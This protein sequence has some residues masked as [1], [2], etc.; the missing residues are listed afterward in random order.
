MTNIRIWFDITNT[1]HVNFFKPIIREFE[2]DYLLVFSIKD[3]AETKLLFE[4]EIHKKHILVGSHK[5]E[6]KVLK[7]LGMLSRTAMLLKRIPGFD[8]KISI[9]GDSSNYAAKLRG[10]KSI[11]FDD[12]E[13][14]FNNRYSKFTDYSFWPTA[15]PRHVIRE[16]GFKDENIYQ[17]D[18]LK[19]DVYIADYLPD[20]DFLSLLPFDNFVV[21]RPENLQANYIRNNQSKTITPKLLSKLITAGYNVLYLP[22]YEVDRCYVKQDSRIFVPDKPINGLDTCYYADAVLTGAGTFAREAACLGVPSFS[23]F[24]GKRLLAVDKS[25]IA[26]GKM[27]H[28]RDVNELMEKLK[29]SRR[30]L[31]TLDKSK[32]VKAEVIQK[33]KEVI[34]S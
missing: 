11:T 14:S 13:T 31:S 24:A 7:V 15:I 23:F 27:F 6:N 26:A 10:K 20:P 8:V 25:M 4:S 28:S 29:S 3:F 2:K 9:G 16:Q 5:G 1:P 19:E 32:Q 21:V 18:G 17:Y 22:R 12:N 34:Q 30:I 33:L